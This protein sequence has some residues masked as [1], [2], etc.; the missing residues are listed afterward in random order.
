MP[1]INGA[2]YAHTISCK[3][4]DTVIAD[5]DFPCI[6]PYTRCRVFA[7]RGGLYVRCQ[8]S[9][10]DEPVPGKPRHHK[11]YL[12]GQL[13]E[14]GEYVGLYHDSERAFLPKKAA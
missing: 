13:N 5:G 10:Q 4:G 2:R 11:H 7:D 8:G 6:E 1:D 12:D 14:H 3:A 9:D